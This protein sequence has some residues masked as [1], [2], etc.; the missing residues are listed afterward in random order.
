MK[1]EV[2]I[3]GSGSAVPLKHRNCTAQVVRILER[4]FLI[5]CGEGTQ[6]QLRRFKIPYNKINHIFISHLHGDHFLGLMGFISSLSLQNRKGALHLYAE[7]RLKELLDF[8]NKLLPSRLNFPLIFHPLSQS[9]ELI[10]EDK[11]VEVY[12][13]PLEHRA[14]MPT[15]GFRINE[16]MRPRSVIKEMADAWEVPLAFM[17]YLKQGADYVAPDGSLVPNARLTKDP[18]L[19]RS[20][21]FMTDTLFRE[22]F[23]EYVR[24]VD[25]LYHEA[26]Y[27]SECEELAHKTGHSTAGEAARLAAAAGAGRLLLGHIS[28]R[29]PDP[30]ALVA[31]ARAI[32]PESFMCADGDKFEIPVD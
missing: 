4:Y 20:Y 28:A 1:F 17:Q 21:G 24:E 11:A 18:P 6:L 23:A 26:T 8:Q 5:D 27:G 3:L 7:P 14:D 10:Y 29:Y 2:T 32:F 12:S 15:C 13:F 30:S 25:L 9:R 22:D 16:K 19:P 31:E